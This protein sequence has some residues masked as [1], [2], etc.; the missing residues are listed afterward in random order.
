MKSNKLPVYKGI[1]VK[2][3]MREKLFIYIFKLK[4]KTSSFFMKKKTKY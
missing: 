2:N 3:C 4:L 1:Y